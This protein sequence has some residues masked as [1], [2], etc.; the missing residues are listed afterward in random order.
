MSQTINLRVTDWTS[1]TVDGQEHASWTLAVTVGDD[2]RVTM[3]CAGDAP[4]TA[5]ES[6][7]LTASNGDDYIAH[8]EGAENVRLITVEA[9]L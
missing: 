3:R 2:G 4:I 9:L 7:D 5:K 1:V 8:E 6:V